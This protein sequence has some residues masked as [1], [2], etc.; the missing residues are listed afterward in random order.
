MANRDKALRNSFFQALDGNLSYNGIEVPITD[1]KMEGDT[2][3]Y[4]LMTE[5][6]ATTS[7]SNNFNVLQ[8]LT[9]LTL[10]I[11]SLQSDSISKDILDDVSD[12]IETIVLAGFPRG[13]GLVVQSSWDI[14]NNG[15]TE[16]KYSLYV[17]TTK[18]LA[19]TKDLTFTQIVT[20]L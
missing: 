20:K 2:N 16:V 19:I 10:Q 11:T 9:T 13:N 18:G 7:P 6:T 1:A 5:Q 8:W 14:I 17:T 4:V 12:Q 15:L 3:V